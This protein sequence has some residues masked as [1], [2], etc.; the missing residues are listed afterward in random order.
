MLDGV[1]R[2][3]VTPPLERMAGL[4]IR[5]GITADAASLIG[6]GW[7]IACG[8]ATAAG[9]FWTALACL[10]MS[11]LADGIDGAIARKTRMTDFG[12]YLDI[13]CDFVFYTSVPLGF[14]L[15]DMGRCAVAASV[16]LASFYL[17]GAS[18]LGFAA[19]AHKRGM[20]TDVRGPKSLYFTTGLTEG[21]ETIAFF[22]ICLLWPAMFPVFALVF[23][24]MC[25]ITFV[26][27]ILHASRV[28]VD[29]RS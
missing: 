1:M 4:V 22:V 13:V 21:T 10:A 6:M 2:R 17:N 16:L 26:S 12:G 14:A 24:A 8:A 3:I 9:W 18:F 19:L 20:D 29:D 15:L 11:R 28:F 7:A 5:M 25:M 23:A 27:R